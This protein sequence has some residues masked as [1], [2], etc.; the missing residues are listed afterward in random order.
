MGR[1]AGPLAE[2]RGVQL[3]CH[4]IGLLEWCWAD[5]R[6]EATASPVRVRRWDVSPPVFMFPDHLSDE[7][8]ISLNI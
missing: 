6:P 3:T 1:P 2:L 4:L 5:V 7:G 8:D